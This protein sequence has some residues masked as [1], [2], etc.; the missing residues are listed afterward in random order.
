[1]DQTRPP[2]GTATT[3]DPVAIRSAIDAFGHWYHRMEL[4]PGVVTPGMN[5]PRPTLAALALPDDLRGKRVLDIGTRDGFFAFECERRGADVVAVD[6]VADTQTGF[7]IAASALGSRVRFVHE[8]IVNLT[9]DEYGTFDVVLMLGLLQH[10]RDPLSGIDAARALCSARLYLETTV[11][12]EPGV[13]DQ[14]F[15]RFWLGDSMSG[16][17]TVFWLPTARCAADLL[18]EA[19]FHVERIEPLDGRVVIEA[20]AVNDEKLLYHGIIARGEQLPGQAA[21]QTRAAAHPALSAAADIARVLGDERY[22]SPRNLVRFGWRAFSQT[23]EDGIIDEIFRRIGTTNRVFVEIGSGDGRVNNTAYLLACGW[24]G[25][26][27]EGNAASA[28]AC[29]QNAAA[30]VAEGRL[31]VVQG[32]VTR[33]NVDELLERTGFAGD[34]DLLSLD[35]DG[36]DYHVMERI[37]SVSPRVV[38]LEYNA[39]YRPPVRWIM[40]YSEAHRWDG[41]AHYGASLSAYDDLMR[42]RGYSL[43]GCNVSGVNAFFVRN[44]LLAGRFDEPYTPEHHF[45]PP[46]YYLTVEYAVTSGHPARIGPAR[47]AVPR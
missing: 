45:E 12:D 44:D 27:I 47:L 40:E 33:D 23:D 38:V 28:A 30:A 10:L 29:E 24:S 16:D 25:G 20:R 14:P 13:A 36:N 18:T 6:Y 5:D 21:P 8:N 19:A 42:E 1:M 43:A 32:M 11:C 35:I 41:T 2:N 15:A 17:P 4:A 31:R 37:A 9:P 3:A 22:A 34:V 46:R 7:A 39:Q 26:W